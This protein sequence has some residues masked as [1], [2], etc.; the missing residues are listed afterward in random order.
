MLAGIEPAH[1]ICKGQIG[2]NGMSPF[3]QFATCLVGHISA[4]LEQGLVRSDPPAA[5]ITAV[6]GVVAITQSVK[7]QLTESW[8]CSR[9]KTSSPGDLP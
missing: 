8:H 7:I 3:E 9:F 4:I 5:N 1:M 6:T 2:R